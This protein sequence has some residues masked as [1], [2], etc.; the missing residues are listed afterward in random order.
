L[1]VRSLKS[2]PLLAAAGA[3]LAFFFDPTSG[4]RRRKLAAERVT[5]LFRR[6]RRRVTHVARGVVAEGSGVKQKATRVQERP[7]PEPDDVTLA[8]KVETQ[9]FRDRDVPKGDINVNAEDG[10]V[11]LRG[12][13]ER[14]ELIGDLEQAARSV[15]G[16]R[17]VENYLHVPG[18]QPQMKQ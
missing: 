4:R 3:G 2:L 8:H 17:Q 1:F 11:Y 18:A 10:V 12:Q 13:V 9:I 16:V 5:G 6:G 14:P 7:R 15:Q